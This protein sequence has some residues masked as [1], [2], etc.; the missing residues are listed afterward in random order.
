[1]AAVIPVTQSEIITLHQSEDDPVSKRQK[2]TVYG[3]SLIP[4]NGSFNTASSSVAAAANVSFNTASSSVEA[5]VVDAVT[6]A[7]GNHDNQLHCVKTVMTK[8]STLGRFSIF[9]HE[10]GTVSSAH[11]LATTLGSL[12]IGIA[13]LEPDGSFHILGDLSDNCIHLPVF[14]YPDQ[15]QFILQKTIEFFKFSDIVVAH[16][17]GLHYSCQSD[18]S[19]SMFTVNLTCALIQKKDEAPVCN[20]QAI[21]T[22]T[23]GVPS[24]YTIFNTYQ[25]NKFFKCLSLILPSAGGLEPGQIS[26][27]HLV[28]HNCT[29]E[30]NLR[31]MLETETTY[32]ALSAPSL[33]SCTNIIQDSSRNYDMRIYIQQNPNFFLLNQYISQ[34]CNEFSEELP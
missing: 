2:T 29:E 34:I 25:L 7:V 27:F 6:E 26:D 9:F 31:T 30:K 4:N 12:R 23:L 3:Y 15:F 16:K 19:L 18:I 22:T 1:M 14:R 24:T 11:F 13:T 32:P 17:K 21:L 20:R 10:F 33:L 28:I 8:L 5:A